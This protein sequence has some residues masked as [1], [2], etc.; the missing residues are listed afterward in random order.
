MT[1][2]EKDARL[3]LKALKKQIDKTLAEDLENLVLAAFIAI[4]R[5]DEKLCHV[6]NAPATTMFCIMGGKTRFYCKTHS[7][8]VLK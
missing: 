1:Q 4:K 8:N 6:C 2:E 7:T 3:A 5:G